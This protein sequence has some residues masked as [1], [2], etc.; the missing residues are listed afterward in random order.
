ML[1]AAMGWLAGTLA[2]NATHGSRIE[3]IAVG[4]FGAFLGGELLYN[5]LRLPAVT[6]GFNGLAMGLAAV[7]GGGMVLLLALFRKANG[8]LKP[9]RTRKAR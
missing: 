8:P 3:D 7:C 6:D 1:G 4:I 2:G 9:H 5:A